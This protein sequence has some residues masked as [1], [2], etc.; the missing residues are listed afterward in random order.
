MKK[1]TLIVGIIVAGCSM[2]I[3][4]NAVLSRDGF[5][6]ETEMGN[7]VLASCETNVVHLRI[8]RSA[9]F[10]KS[11]IWLNIASSLPDGITVTFEPNPSRG[12]LA[13]AHF[14]VSN[15]KKVE[16]MPLIVSGDARTPGWPK[17]GAIL[18]ISTK[19]TCFE[20]EIAHESN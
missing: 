17:K 11:P 18:K 6:V 16:N 14:V 8:F 1:I 19:E 15:F 2:P 12:D 10:S 5:R 4:K 20:K 7:A 3:Q 9:G 13:T